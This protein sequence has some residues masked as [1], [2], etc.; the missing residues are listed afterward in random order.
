MS[1]DIGFL[2]YSGWQITRQLY[3]YEMSMPICICN[4][5]VQ[6]ISLLSEYCVF[7][8]LFFF[9]HDRRDRYILHALCCRVSGL[10]WRVEQDNLCWRETKV[11]QEYVESFVATSTWQLSSRARTLDKVM[12]PVYIAS[13]DRTTTTTAFFK[14]NRTPRKTNEIQQYYE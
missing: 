9:F 12:L 3:R 7:F 8:F 2:N 4:K 1:A 10:P 5:S 11:L 6:G 13:V 14:L